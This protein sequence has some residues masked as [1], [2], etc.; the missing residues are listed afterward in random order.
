MGPLSLDPP[1]RTLFYTV[2]K[3]A[4]PVFFIEVRPV[5]GKNMH[6]LLERYKS[7]ENSRIVLT[8]AGLGSRSLFHVTVAITFTPHAHTHAH[9]RF[10]TRTSRRHCPPPPTRSSDPLIHAWKMI[11][12]PLLRRDPDRHKLDASRLRL[13]RAEQTLT[14]SYQTC[15][16]EIYSTTVM[17]MPLLCPLLPLNIDAVVTTPCFLIHK[18]VSS[19][20]NNALIENNV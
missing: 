16:N 11:I 6:I 13:D 17:R 8:C 20:V 12:S 7:T 19:S 4:Q 10:R 9:V 1:Y 3:H 18:C 14:T 2:L 15:T 5:E